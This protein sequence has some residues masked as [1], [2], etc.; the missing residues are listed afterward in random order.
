MQ[1]NNNNDHRIILEYYTDPLCCWS[2]ALE[3]HLN[4]LLEKQE[5]RIEFRYFM[6]GL[7]P[8]WENYG[9]PLNDIS[10]PA[11]M[12]PF[13]MHVSRTA[14]VEIN[15]GVWHDDPPVSS[16]PACIAVKCAEKQSA[17]AGYSLLN[18][19]R[20]AIMLSGLNISKNQVIL[21]VAEELSFEPESG[22]DFVRFRNDF[23]S[24]NAI[25]DFRNDLLLKEKN[26]ISRLPGIILKNKSGKGVVILGY[27]PYDLLESIFLDFQEK[28]IK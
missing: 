22:F 4:K 16:Y 24:G 6:G 25:D 8:D 28:N 27:R 14:G 18:R 21:D 12:A 7:I 2:W 20:K 11:Q 3:P 26:R 13:W 23:K 9:D 5:D 19:L 10:R 15:T 1:G 17:G